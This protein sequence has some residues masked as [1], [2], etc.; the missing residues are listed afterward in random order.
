MAKEQE[1]TMN[2]SINDDRVIGEVQI[3]DEVVAIIAGL[4]EPK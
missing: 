3:A 4:S 2:Y 1:N